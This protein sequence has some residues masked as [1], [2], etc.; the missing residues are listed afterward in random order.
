MD[1][2]G[3]T[4]HIDTSFMHTLQSLYILLQHITD[5]KVPITMVPLQQHL[6]PPQGCCEQVI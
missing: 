1:V 2:V 6:L 3:S 4:G 5:N